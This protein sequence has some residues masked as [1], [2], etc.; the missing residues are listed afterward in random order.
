[1]TQ[2]L[3]LGQIANSAAPATAAA[4]LYVMGETYGQSVGADVA[5]L[6]ETEDVAPA[7]S[8]GTAIGRRIE[9]PVTYDAA[10]TVRLTPI[11]DFVQPSTVTDVAYTAPTRRTVDF[12]DGFFAQV[13]TA[14]RVRTEVLTR[15]G[16]VELAAPTVGAQVKTLVASAPV[17]TNT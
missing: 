10:A 11:V 5:L 2:K 4:E 8:T 14:F 1:M 9:Q 17:G 12:A 7:G 3:L 15:N 6:V 13:G 16:P